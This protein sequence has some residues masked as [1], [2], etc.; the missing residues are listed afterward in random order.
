MNILILAPHPDDE[1]LGAGGTIAK[2]VAA[3]D[4][5]TVAVLTGHGDTPHPIWPKTAWDTVRGECKEAATV[6]GVSQLIFSELPAAC[7]DNIPSWQTNKSVQEIIEETDPEQLYIPFAGD[8]HR[9]HGA[10]AYAASVVARPY[11]PTGKAIKRI[12]AYETL[13][14]T[15]LAPAYLEPA[16]QPTYFVD[17][18]EYLELK[19]KAM[20]CYNSQLKDDWN[21]RSLRALTALAHLRGSHIGVES[22]EAF[23]ILRELG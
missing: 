9:D 14:E 1:V 19:L 12:V 16:F 6:L 23:I 11:L 18:S 15:H 17:I 13:S 2:H 21:P 10:I 20:Q 22:A 5:V 4:C 7:L 8:L 3:G